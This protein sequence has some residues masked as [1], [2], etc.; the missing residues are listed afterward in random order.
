MKARAYAG[1]IV[2]EPCRRDTAAAAAVAF[3]L[4]KRQ[5]ALVGVDDLVVPRH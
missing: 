5:I 1:N 2:G 3:G 4:V